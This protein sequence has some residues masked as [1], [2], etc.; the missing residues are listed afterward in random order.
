MNTVKNYVI[1]CNN[2]EYLLRL[3]S[4]EVNLNLFT[5]NILIF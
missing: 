5:I 2:F 3:I 4:K 1:Y